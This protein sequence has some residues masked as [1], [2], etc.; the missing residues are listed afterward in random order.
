MDGHS[1]RRGS[2]TRSTSP[3][4]SAGTRS[5]GATRREPGHSTA[6][7][8]PTPSPSTGCSAWSRHWSS[9]RTGDGMNHVE[10]LPLGTAALH[11]PRRARAVELWRAR[12]LGGPVLRTLLGANA[13]VVLGTAAAAITL[14]VNEPQMWVTLSAALLLTFAVNGGLVYLALRPL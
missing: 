10:R 5:C 14:H 2:A 4:A 13:V 1:R 9:P 6:T 12:M 3:R 8:F 11:G 7:F